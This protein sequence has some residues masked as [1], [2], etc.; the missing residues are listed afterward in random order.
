MV[1]QLIKNVLLWNPNVH[2]RN[3]PLSWARWMQSTIFFFKIHLNVI[4]PRMSPC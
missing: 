1:T 2:S 4:F 3:W